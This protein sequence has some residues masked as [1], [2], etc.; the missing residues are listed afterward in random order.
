MNKTMIIMVELLKKKN[1]FY[2]DQKTEWERKVCNSLAAKGHFYA[3]ASTKCSSQW[4]NH[5]SI[6]TC[7]LSLRFC[8]FT[9]FPLS[10]SL[11]HL[12]PPPH[13]QPPRSPSLT[14]P[15]WVTSICALATNLNICYLKKKKKKKKEK[16]KKKKNHLLA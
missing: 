7:F 9:I 10:Q 2:K 1:I 8:Y 5:M 15:T 11:P 14:S 12:L 4:I 16:K 13:P 3:H 6:F